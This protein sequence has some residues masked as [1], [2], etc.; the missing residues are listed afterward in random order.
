MLQSMKWRYLRYHILSYPHLMTNLGR[1]DPLCG[2]G[3]AACCTSQ[4]HHRT[5]HSQANPACNSSASACISHFIV[6]EVYVRY[7]AKNGQN[8]KQP[9]N[10]C[11]IAGFHTNNILKSPWHSAEIIRNCSWCMLAPSASKPVKD[12][13]LLNP[14]LCWLSWN[15]GYCDLNVISLW[16]LIPSELPHL[17]H[18]SHPC[19]RRS[20]SVKPAARSLGAAA[21]DIIFPVDKMTYSQWTWPKWVVPYQLWRF[22][23]PSYV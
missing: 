10:V 7:R 2:L 4:P 5:G 3:E 15:L 8:M 11:S 12:S 17:S 6:F 9:W 19:L 23:L 16:S 13:L 20:V 22:V 18:L 1:S 21:E 14:W